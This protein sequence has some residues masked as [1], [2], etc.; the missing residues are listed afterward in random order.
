MITAGLSWMTLSSDFELL[1]RILH[2]FLDN[3]SA[4]L[5][6]DA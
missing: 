5:K 3:S 6:T 2:R 4:P 1:A